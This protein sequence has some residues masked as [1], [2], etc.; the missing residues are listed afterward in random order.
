MQK[1]F[2]TLLGPASKGLPRVFCTTQT[3]FC[4]GATPFRT[5]ARGLLPAG[6]KRAF[7]PSPNG[8][9]SVPRER[10]RRCAEKRLSKRVF[11]ESPFLLCPLRF[12]GPSGVSRANLKGAE[13]KRTLQKHPFGQPLLRTTPWLGGP[14]TPPF[15]PSLCTCFR[16]QKIRKSENQKRSLRND[17]CDAAQPGYKSQKWEV[18][19]SFFEGH[20]V[21]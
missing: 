18:N 21:I 9:Q 3:L 6:S 11:L 15:G 7:A 1:V 5:S 8:S 4:T 2:L 10:R 16:N 17:F 14:R 20:E 19:N 13:K 12:S